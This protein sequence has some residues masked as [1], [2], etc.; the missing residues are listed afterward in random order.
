MFILNMVDCPLF[1]PMLSTLTWD[2]LL[3]LRGTWGFYLNHVVPP[4]PSKSYGW[5]EWGGGP[6]DFSVSPSL[7]ELDNSEF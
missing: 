2:T 5:V 6:L 7:R 4:R 1:F 3:T